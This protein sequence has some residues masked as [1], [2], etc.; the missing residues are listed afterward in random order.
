M[1]SRRHLLLGAG[2]SLLAHGAT[3][4]GLSARPRLVELFTS[5]GCSSCP[6]ADRLLG[7]LARRDDVIALAFHVD[8][9]DHLGWRDPYA[10]RVFTERQR[11]YQRSLRARH[12]YT[13]QMVIDGVHDVVGSDRA[14]VVERLRGAPAVAPVT[15]GLTSGAAGTV[16]RIEGEAPNAEIWVARFDRRRETPIA[17]GEN[18]GRTLEEFHIARGLLRL[19]A[20][21][22]GRF[23]RRLATADLPGEGDRLAVWVQTAGLGPVL[24]AAAASLA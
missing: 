13:P 7:E 5:Q 16:L 8:Y 12:V 24:G 10:Q 1:P 22:G 9:W 20:W 11:A 21:S 14:A 19:A 15:V 6:P 18:A 3:A 2:A 23:E 17:R 4:A